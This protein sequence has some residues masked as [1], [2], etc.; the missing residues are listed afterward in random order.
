M[1]ITLQS[2]QICIDAPFQLC[3]NTSPVYRRD[4]DY[5]MDELKRYIDNTEQSNSLKNNHP[6]D[7]CAES[8]NGQEP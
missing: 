2:L 3:N 8:D 4:M 7:F 1:G 5:A 6:E